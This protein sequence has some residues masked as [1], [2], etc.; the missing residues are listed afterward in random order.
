MSFKKADSKAASSGYWGWVGDVERHEAAQKRA[1]PKFRLSK[2]DQ[3][4]ASLDK[5]YLLERMRQDFALTDAAAAA[6]RNDAAPR[7]RDAIPAP[8]PICRSLC[9]DIFQR[10]E[11]AKFQQWRNKM[12]AHEAESADRRATFRRDAIRN[13]TPVVHSKPFR[14][15][16]QLASARPFESVEHFAG[17][18]D[19]VDSYNES[20]KG[21]YTAYDQNNFTTVPELLDQTQRHVTTMN[22]I[23]V[24]HTDA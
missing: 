23:A 21:Y 9:G 20:K 7:K 15:T 22:H 17:G 11:D 10:Q 1:T 19:G 4:V 8:D 16:K 6:R 18:W 14:P 2:D 5:D 24:H 3:A 13:V 12:D